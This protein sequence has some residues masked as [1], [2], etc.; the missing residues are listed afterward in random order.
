MDN[1]RYWHFREKS[2]LL[3][4]AIAGENIFP[5]LEKHHI[6]WWEFREWWKAYKVGGAKALRTTRRQKV[7]AYY[8]AKHPLKI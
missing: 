4:R 1:V 8:L 7:I 2:K 5:I 3:K 6:T